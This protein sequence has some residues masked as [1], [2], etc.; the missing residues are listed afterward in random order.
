MR[1]WFMRHD[2]AYLQDIIESMNAAVNYLG[3][4]S[5][6]QLAADGRTLD[7]IIRRI[8]I[9][10]EATKRLSNELRQRNPHVPWREMAGMRDRV[11]HGYDR[12]DIAHVYNATKERMTALLPELSRLLDSLPDPE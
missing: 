6:A 10:G 3:P 5:C 8:G 9:I 2:K 1:E 11:V 4:Y 7:A 12:V